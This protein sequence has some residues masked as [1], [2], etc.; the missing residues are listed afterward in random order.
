LSSTLSD[1]LQKQTYGEQNLQKSEANAPEIIV[2]VTQCVN[3]GCTTVSKDSGH[4]V[5][6]LVVFSFEF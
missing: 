2:G 1:L 5:V 3:K 4:A 6:D